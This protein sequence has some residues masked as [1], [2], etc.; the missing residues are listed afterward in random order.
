M[1]NVVDFGDNGARAKQNSSLD[2]LPHV[3]SA[4]HSNTQ[5]Q[6]IKVNV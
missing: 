5:T 1:W 4:L 3:T 2:M 6:E